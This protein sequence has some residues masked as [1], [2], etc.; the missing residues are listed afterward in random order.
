MMILKENLFKLLSNSA[1]INIITWDHIFKKSSILPKT[2]C[3][4]NKRILLSQL[5][6][7]G[8]HL[9]PNIKTDVTETHKLKS[10]NSKNKMKIIVWE[11][12]IF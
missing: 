8:T 9:P 4:A 1:N 2:T 7:F 3:N 6:K 10:I 11:L 5:S 12:K